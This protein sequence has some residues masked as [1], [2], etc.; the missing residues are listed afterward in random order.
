MK[1]FLME[2]SQEQPKNNEI[3]DKIDNQTLSYEHIN[4]LKNSTLNREELIKTITDN[5]KLFDKKNEYSKL[6]YLKKKHSKFSKIIKVVKPSAREL[7]EMHF[8]KT[9]AKIRFL[10]WDVLAQ[11]LEKSNVKSGSNVLIIEDVMGLITLGVWERLR[12]SGGTLNICNGENFSQSLGLLKCYDGPKPE[13]HYLSWNVIRQNY[14]D[15]LSEQEE[16]QGVDESPKD[17]EMMTNESVDVKQDTKEAF[18]ERLDKMKSEDRK[19]RVTKRF[20][21]LKSTRDYMKNTKFDA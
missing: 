7:S 17:L 14:L 1:E 3:F 10:Q 5:N 2:G 11:L 4:N 13:E 6:K 20:V 21:A 15:G 9:P 19:I 18:Q 16:V 8:E 12:G